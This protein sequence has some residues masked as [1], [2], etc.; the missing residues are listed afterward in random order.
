MKYLY[1]FIVLLLLA[2]RPA[3]THADDKTSYL[4]SIEIRDRKVTRANREIE[5]K[6]VVDLSE[7]RIRTQHTVALTPVLVAADG[8]RELELPP[9]VIDG[10]TRNKI[11]SRAQRLESVELPPYHDGSA[12]V[13]IRRT[14]GK[15]QSYDYRATVPY[16]RWMLGGHIEIR[17]SVF[18]CTNCSK[19][20][21]S[22]PLPEGAN[23]LA[24]FEPRYSVAPIMPE[25][26]AVKARSETRTARLQFRQNSRKIDPRFK[27][28][29]TE[30]DAVTA[31]IEVVKENKDLTITGIYITGYASPEGTVAYNERLSLARAEVLAAHARKDTKLDASL[32][33]VTS[34]GEDWK[35]LREE[36]VK[37]PRLLKIDKVLE[38]IDNGDADLDRREEQLKALVPPDIYKR[39]ITEMYGPLR[40]NEYRVEYNVRRFDLE[41]AKGQITTRPDLLSV[42]EMYRVAESH[43]EGTE[44]YREALLTAARTYPGNVAA[45]VNA[46][47][48]E[49]DRG[50]APAAIRLLEESQ[51]TDTPEALNAL[52]VAYALDGKFEKA[53]E[54]LTRA[55]AAG[56]SEAE[57]NLQQVAG[58]IEDL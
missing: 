22:R 45:V 29:R 20:E 56:S 52:G 27:N 7:A 18:G 42:E 44:A 54:A 5:L 58:M 19:G 2:S 11:Y 47:R 17:E 46:A 48:V 53:R 43:G 9:V 8:S 57:G 23:A 28:N 32:W 12:Q 39:L 10:R 33:H 38:I 14:N 16:E 41:E 37:H 1:S 13:V 30:L 3:T 6:M 26:E 35:G 50:N 40:R 24:A 34:A 21:A 36:V 25:P 49:L 4:S 15:E 55:K 51:V 31:S